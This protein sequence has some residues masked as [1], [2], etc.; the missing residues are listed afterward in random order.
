MTSRYRSL[1]LF[2]FFL[3]SLSVYIYI[4]IYISPRCTLL[5]PLSLLSLFSFYPF[6]ERNSSSLTRTHPHTLSSPSEHNGTFCHP[7]ECSINFLCFRHLLRRV[8]LL[9]HRWQRHHQTTLPLSVSFIPTYQQY[10]AR[11]WIL[12]DPR[13]ENSASARHAYQDPWN[14]EVPYSVAGIQIRSPSLGHYRHNGFW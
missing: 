9:R 11:S 1:S 13:C 6:R 12:L 7:L 3:F 2:V 5:R 14:H 8:A 4:Y 10:C